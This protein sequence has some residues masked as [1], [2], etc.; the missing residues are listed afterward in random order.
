[1]VWL[2]HKVWRSI[3]FYDAST[4]IVTGPT[5]STVKL[6]LLEEH[7]ENGGDLTSVLWLASGLE[8]E[9]AL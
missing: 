3:K 6:K 1:M 7:V 4:H 9:Q 2:F 5:Q 8:I